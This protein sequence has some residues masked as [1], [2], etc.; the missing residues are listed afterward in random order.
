MF[1]EIITVDQSL[2]NQVAPNFGFGMFIIIRSVL[3][4]V[5]LHQIFWKQV[6]RYRNNGIVSTASERITL[7]ATAG[8]VFDLDYNLKLKAIC[9]SKTTGCTTFS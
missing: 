8:Y 7:F 5:F 1:I 2:I 6:S 3:C 9:S 4:L